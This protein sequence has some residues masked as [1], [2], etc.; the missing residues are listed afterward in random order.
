MANYLDAILSIDSTY[1]VSISGDPSVYSNIDWGSETPIAQATLDAILSTVNLNQAK[2]TKRLEIKAKRNE[3]LSRYVNY[4]GNDHEMSSATF[5]YL[6]GASAFVSGGG[7]L[8]GTFKVPL[9]DGTGVVADATYVQGLLS[10]T[11][12]QQKNHMDTYITKMASIDAATDIATVE[13]ITWS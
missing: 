1:E 5:S 3:A 9:T 4:S 8:S 11:M 13:A 2:T 7:T 6:I 12:S 10:N